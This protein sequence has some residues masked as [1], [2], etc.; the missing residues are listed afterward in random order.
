LPYNAVV[1]QPID[2]ATPAT[3]EPGWFP[4][5]RIAVT[6]PIGPVMVLAGP[7]AGKT[8]CL[9]G[10]IQYLV[11]ELHAAPQ[12]ICA[13]TFTNKAAEEIIARLRLSMGAVAERPWLGTIH[14]LCL[15]LLR[16]FARTMGL[17]PGF[18]VADEAQQ[19]AILARL[20]IWKQ[21]H[22]QLLGLFGLRRLTRY[23][24]TPEDE[25]NF[26]AYC[27]ELERHRLIDYDGIL[28]LTRQLLDK[29]PGALA[30]FQNRWDHLLVDEFQDLDPCQYEILALL[31]ARHRSLFVVGDDEQSIFAWRGAD[32]NLARRFQLEFQAKPI[33]LDVNCRCS[34]PIFETARRILPQDG[35][36]L[37]K[38]IRAMR[39]GGGPVRAVG[40]VDEAAE[41]EWVVNDI[42]E[43]LA[44]S[45]LPRGEYAVLYRNHDMGPRI[46]Q[47]LLA[48]GIPCRLGKGRAM[49][50]DDVIRQLV[51]SLRIVLSPDSD[52]DVE[53][54]AHMVLPEQVLQRLGFEREGRFVDSLRAFAQAN[55][56]AKECWRLLYQLENLT[57][58]RASCQTLGELVRGV[59]SLGI[60]RY[61]NPLEKRFEKLSDPQDL[62]LAREL[63]DAI[64]ETI[65]A[66]GRVLVSAAQGLE[67]VAA[68][69][70]RKA[71]PRVEIGYARDET[72]R[73]ADLVIDLAGTSPARSVSLVNADGLRV[74]TLFKALQ[75]VEARNDRKLLDEY[76]VFDTETTGKEVDACEVVELAAAR[77][78]GG[79][80]VDRFRSLIH[81]QQ[82]ITPGAREVHGYTDEDLKGQPEFAEVWQKFRAFVGDTVLVAHNALRFD[83]PVLDRLAAGSGG[84]K[85]MPVFDTLPL[86]RQLP[87]AGGVSQEALAARFGVETGRSHH[88]LDDCICLAGV[89]EGLMREYLKTMRMTS[90]VPLLEYVA[91]GAALEETSRRSVEDD[92]LVDGGTWKLFGKYSRLLAGFETEA[93]VHSVKCPTTAEITE[94]LG[95]ATVLERVKKTVDPEDR[96]AESYARFRG[97][98][99]RGDGAE[100]EPAIREFLDTV[101]LS[102]SDGTGTDSEHVNLLS[103][104]STKGLEFSRVYVLGVED[105]CLPGWRAIKEDREDEIREA[106][107]LL[108]VAMTRAED[109]LI[110]TRCEMRNG[111]PTGGTRF[112]SDLGLTIESR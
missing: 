44:R 22:K 39:V 106:R 50:D 32:P 57:G 104:H 70:L 15:E 63:S 43:D 25:A 59:L 12:R 87:G 60:G 9:A 71:L 93:F 108:Y 20:R 19:L 14:A 78:R 61:P 34:V 58:L 84:L 86:A 37:E 41:A 13:V 105:D 27:S 36:L 28:A 75:L 102:R 69:M 48:R 24:L 18:G 42:L 91:L 76:V 47:G 1:P 33:V 3:T 53:A 31:A 79:K 85:D 66:D 72:P 55:R 40:F 109:R 54:L 6:A 45:K 81:C 30:S 51:T 8:R 101:A 112:L 29:D 2:T 11:E 94:R 89:V 111:R 68:L 65:S 7:G 98:V 46:E 80:V 67:V 110:L 5:Q 26:Q 16:P 97:L 38:D 82:P 4:A 49:M 21:R 107:R 88:A 62:P 90:Q 64:A 35:S 99:E 74:T 10:R 100:L 83:V 92:A 96:Y 73:P 95:G 52:L 17:P 103:L 56:S 23:R 77:V